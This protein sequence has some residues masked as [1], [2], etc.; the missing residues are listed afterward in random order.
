MKRTPFLL[1]ATLFLGVPAMAQLFIQQQAQT[2]YDQ[3]SYAKALELLKKAPDSELNRYEIAVSLF[4]TE[5]WDE[6]IKA[7]NDALQTAQWKARLYICSA[8]FMS[9]RPKRAGNWA[10]KSGVRTNIPKL[11][12]T[13]NH[14]N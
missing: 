4:K 13:K 10:T 6:A 3:K 7:T 5:K 11:K 1:L 8:K 14:C 12:A 2:A 9:K